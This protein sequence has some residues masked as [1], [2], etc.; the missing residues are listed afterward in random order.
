[1]YIVDG[2]NGSQLA[3]KT[4]NTRYLWSDEDRARFE[5]EA[6][7]WVRLD[8]HPNVVTARK[9]EK[10]EGLPCLVM[11]YIDGGDLGFLLD[12]NRLTIAGALKCALQI[13]DGMRHASDQLGLVHRDLKPSNCMVS[14]DGRIKV[15]DFGLALAMRESQEQSLALTGAPD[16][17]RVLYTTVAGTPVYMAP[18]QYMVGAR[19]G[20]WTDVYAFGVLLYEMLTGEVPP[21]GGKAKRFIANPNPPTGRATLARC[22]RCWRP[23]IAE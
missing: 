5:R 21:P 20:P 18:E 15:T 4:F 1:V 2:P 7:T 23:S 8:P 9:I 3:F 13:C 19:L 22:A 10:I 12:T 14:R 11:D 16:P 17:V 6:A